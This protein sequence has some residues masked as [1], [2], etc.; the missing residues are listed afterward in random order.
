MNNNDNSSTVK[1]NDPSL[2]SKRNRKKLLDRGPKITPKQTFSLERTITCPKDT[3][4]HVSD[5]TRNKLNILVPMKGAENVDAIID[6]IIDEYIELVLTK[7][8]KEA[9]DFIYE[10]SQKNK[11]K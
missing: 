11:N 6:I 8:E 2:V 7:K 9:F 4:I 3:R 10:L 5:N 1:V